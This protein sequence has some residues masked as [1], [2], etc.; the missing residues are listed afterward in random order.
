MTVFMSRQNVIY[1]KMEPVYQMEMYVVH[2]TINN[3]V[4][5]PIGMELYDSNT[6]L[7]IRQAEICITNNH[8]PQNMLMLLKQQHKGLAYVLYY[9]IIHMYSRDIRV[10]IS[11]GE[12][13]VF[14]HV[15]IMMVWEQK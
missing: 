5:L 2:N 10:I 8:F 4:V 11:D 6:A 3:I 13:K 9:Y 7:S 1:T 15:I 12:Q 14:L